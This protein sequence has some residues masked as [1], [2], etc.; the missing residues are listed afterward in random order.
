M[1]H[2]VLPDIGFPDHYGLTEQEFKI[3]EGNG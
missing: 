2:R 3:I 1:A